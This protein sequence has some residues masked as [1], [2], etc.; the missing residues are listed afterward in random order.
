MIMPIFFNGYFLIRGA[1]E[2]PETKDKVWVE[3]WSETGLGQLIGRGGGW[4][5]IRSMP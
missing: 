2:L 5:C 1:V 4:R 3:W